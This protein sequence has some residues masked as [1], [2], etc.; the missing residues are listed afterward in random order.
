MTIENV[1][2]SFLAFLSSFGLDALT[3][4]AHNKD[5]FAEN[6]CLRSAFLHHKIQ[7]IIYASNA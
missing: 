1:K 2:Q 5:L 7:F 4:V 3:K 6:N